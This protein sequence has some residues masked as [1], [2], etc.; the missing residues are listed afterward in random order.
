MQEVI[1]KAMNMLHHTCSWIQVMPTIPQQCYL[2]D[3]YTQTHRQ[4]QQNQYCLP[5]Q[6][7]VIHV[8]PANCTQDKPREIPHSEVQHD[9]I[10]VLYIM[11]ISFRQVEYK[12]VLNSWLLFNLP[13]SFHDTNRL[14]SRSSIFQ[15]CW[16]CALSMCT[17]IKFH[18]CCLHGLKAFSC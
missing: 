7:W 10:L 2:G 11:Y 13:H 3:E 12:K 15:T 17:S 4:S 5:C 14:K 16:I 1:I 8:V 18:V 6:K 9:K